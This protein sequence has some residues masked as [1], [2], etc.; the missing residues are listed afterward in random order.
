MHGPRTFLLAWPKL[1]STLWILYAQ[2]FGCAKADIPVGPP[3][4]FA[5]DQGKPELPPTGW[6]TRARLPDDDQRETPAT[7]V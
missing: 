5:M 1:V 2:G 6:V 3:C 7:I 4:A